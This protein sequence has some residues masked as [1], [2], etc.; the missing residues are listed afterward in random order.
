[1]S[2][3]EKILEDDENEYAGFLG[4]SCEVRKRDRTCVRSLGGRKFSKLRE[5]LSAN[6][7]ETVTG[8]GEPDAQNLREER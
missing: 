2:S 4:E 1:M 6:G 5:A 8:R 7:S 3:E